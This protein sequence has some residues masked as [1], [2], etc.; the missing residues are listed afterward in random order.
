M[1]K[2]LHLQNF[3]NFRDETLELGPLTLLVGANA[4]GK[5]NVLDALRLLQGLALE[6]SVADAVRGRW[7]GGRPVWP[8]IRG[9]LGDLLYRGASELGLRSTWSLGGEE[10][11]HELALQVEPTPQVVRERLTSSQVLGEYLLDTHAPALGTQ[12]GLVEGGAL[13]VALKRDGSGKS[14]T[15]SYSASRLVLGQVQGLQ[16][17]SG[18]VLRVKEQTLHAMRASFFL[19][20]MPARMRD[21]VN[22]NTDQLGLSGENISAILWSICRDAEARRDLVDWLSELCAPE[23]EELRFEETRLG[24][25]M[26]ILVERGGREIP[27]RSLSDGTLRFLGQLVALRTA[28]PGSLL[29][30]E[31]PENGLHPKRAHL[32]VEAMD[33]ATAT[34]DVQIIAT[35]HSPFVLNALSAE[36]LR[37]AVLVARPPGE[38]SARLK[39]LGELPGFEAVLER[40]GIE[41]MMLTGWLERAV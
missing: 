4:S 15:G 28:P 41:Q 9:G 18:E 16:G 33:A 39:R 27:A 3:K 19:E 7:E 6:M 37:E 24:D 30:L 36:A 29:L 8:G 40:R 32:L 11:V 5:S 22:K 17:L 34:R 21:Y 31:E 35:T 25:V 38:E 13:R 1:L 12:Q 10:I 20:V 23:V 26:L 14:P 2:Q